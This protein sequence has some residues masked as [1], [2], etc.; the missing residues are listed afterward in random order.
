MGIQAGNESSCGAAIPKQMFRLLRCWFNIPDNFTSQS[1]VI[2]VF[3][4]IVGFW[5]TFIVAGNIWFTQSKV[6]LPYRHM[7]NNRQLHKQPTITST[8]PT[9]TSCWNNFH[10]HWNTIIYLGQSW[11]FHIG[12]AANAGISSE[13]EAHDWNYRVRWIYLRWISKKTLLGTTGKLATR[14]SPQPSVSVY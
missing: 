4:V 3:D 1:H 7:S 12:T 13:E 11:Y 9:I 5:K 8:S 10:R 14:F 2:D 6:I